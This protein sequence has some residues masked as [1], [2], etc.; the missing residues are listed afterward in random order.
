MGQAKI[1]KKVRYK[2]K[3]KKKKPRT[4]DAILNQELMISR[5]V[6]N[7]LKQQNKK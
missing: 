4:F 5:Q 3:N 1:L 7:I 6:N 2:T